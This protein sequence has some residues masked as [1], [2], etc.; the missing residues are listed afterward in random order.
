MPSV[1]VAYETGAMLDSTAFAFEHMLS[2]SSTKENSLKAAVPLQR[3]LSLSCTSERTQR[4]VCG[5]QASMGDN[6]QMS[7]GLGSL[8]CAGARGKEESQDMEIMCIASRCKDSRDV[9]DCLCQQ[10]KSAD[11]HHVPFEFW[12]TCDI[13]DDAEAGAGAVEP[14]YRE[15]HLSQQASFPQCI[16]EWAYE[17]LPRDGLIMLLQSALKNKPADEDVVGLCMLAL[18]PLTVDEHD[19][20]FGASGSCLQ[21]AA[22]RVVP[23]HQP[24]V[25][26][27]EVPAVQSPDEQSQITV[28]AY[29]TP[30]LEFV[31][32]AS[33]GNN[34]RSRSS[35]NAGASSVSAAVSI[36]G[37]FNISQESQSDSSTSSTTMH[38]TDGRAGARLSILTEEQAIQ[39]FKQRIG[40]AVPGR[41][42]DR[43]SLCSDLA[44]RYG[45]SS[46][47]I[48]HIW[49]RRTWIWTNLPFWTPTE[50]KASL[51]VG[52][53]TECRS[54]N[55]DKIEDTCAMCPLNRKRGRPRGAR[56]TFN[57]V[58][59]DSEMS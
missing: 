16:P 30:K 55:V 56:D 18:A 50:L 57:H 27:L 29:Y 9:R 32:P 1:S 38:P 15:T 24:A 20:C 41:C 17:T 28:D 53:C 21:A 31:S 52:T 10:C 35:S 42:S 46:T 5:A 6:E 51:A 13:M 23:Q 39:V 48:R 26:I 25:D 14:T 54:R 36:N 4:Q 43:T 44:I 34:K 58:R 8:A 49:E 37:R 47:A 22:A 40:Q 45:V 59:K 2:L 12:H 7:M 11:E 33:T 3:I 19:E